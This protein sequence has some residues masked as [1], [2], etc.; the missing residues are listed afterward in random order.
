MRLNW[1]VGGG[2][3]CWRGVGLNTE[4]G[5]DT[6]PHRHLPPFPPPLIMALVPSHQA[7]ALG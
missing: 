4:E 3:G 7:R 5:E 1:G 2:R 6:V